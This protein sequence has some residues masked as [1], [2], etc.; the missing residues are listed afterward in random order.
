MFIPFCMF[1]PQ[2]L[3]DIIPAYPSISQHIPSYP[4]ISQHKNPS[5]PNCPAKKKLSQ[6]ETTKFIPGLHVHPQN[7]PNKNPKFNRKFKLRSSCSPQNL[8]VKKSSKKQHPFLSMTLH[9]QVFMFVNI[10]GLAYFFRMLLRMGLVQ[11]AK[12]A[13]EGSLEAS[14]EPR[15]AA[16]AEQAE[17]QQCPIC[18]EDFAEND[19]ETW[20]RWMERLVV[21]AFFWGGCEFK[22]DSVNMGEEWV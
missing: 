22:N 18:L 5:Q 17:C 8:H 10:I 2:N 19:A 6:P 3:S 9:Q 15:S 20:Q 7:H 11:S 4:N 1:L 12:A 13:P 21:V 14:T 16:E